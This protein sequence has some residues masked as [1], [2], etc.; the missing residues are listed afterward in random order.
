[1]D[2]NRFAD[3]HCSVSRAAGVAADPW[4]LLILRDL[5]LGLNRYEE[6]RRDLGIAT[7]VLADRLDR[8]VAD[9]LAERHAY[10][11]NP[12]RHAYRLTP[13]GRDLYPV[14][15]TLLAW[16]DRHRSEGGPPLRLLHADCGHPAVP[17][18]TCSHCGG[19]LTPETTTAAPG[20]GGRAAPGTALV[21]GRLPT[22]LGP[23]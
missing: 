11:D 1:M 13:A 15:L 17:S 2:R 14:L 12:L 4:T 10:Q 20:P 22:S 16:G 6:L 7:N 8:L 23:A 18:L 9:G 3:I 19:A 5:F 21:P